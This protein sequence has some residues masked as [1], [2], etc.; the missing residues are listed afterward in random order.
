M[1]QLSARKD[2]MARVKAGEHGSM[3]YDI[4]HLTLDNIGE[5][6]GLA[7]KHAVPHSDG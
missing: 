2:C 7:M 6:P 5:L 3:S 1:R 4:M